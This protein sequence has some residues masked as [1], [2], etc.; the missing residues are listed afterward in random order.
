VKEGVRATFLDLSS[1]MTTRVQAK[2]PKE[3]T[4]NVEV[5]NEEFMS[6]PLERSSFDL[7]VS[8][9]VMAH[10]E[11]PE[12][13]VAKIASLL[14]PKGCAIIEFTDCKHP[15][16][17]L[18]RFTSNLK[19]LVAPP[20]YRT[21]RLSSKIVS[22]IFGM[23]GLRMLSLYRYSTFPIP[24]FQRIVSQDMQYRLIRNI[25]SS[26]DNNRNAWLGNEYIC[27]LTVD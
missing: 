27:F 6:A 20:K 1:S 21:N 14:R 16:G 8:V 11:S 7:I 5:K 22:R 12:A 18:A 3:W 15:I 19:E 13:F 10:V 17:R 26:A 9:G 2:I 25:F 24:G 23:Y 4:Q